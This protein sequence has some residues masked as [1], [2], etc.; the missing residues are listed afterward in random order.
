MMLFPSILQS[1]KKQEEEKLAEVMEGGWLNR[2]S[3]P[4]TLE[5]ISFDVL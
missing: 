5:R 4:L 1:R 2:N 3:L